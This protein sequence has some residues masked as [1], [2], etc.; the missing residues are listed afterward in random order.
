MPT[1]TPR[2]HRIAV[3]EDSDALREELLSWLGRADLA[4]GFVSGGAF[5]LS[6]EKLRPDL[7]VLDLGLPGFD[8]IEIAQRVRADPR[9]RGVPILFLAASTPGDIDLPIAC[10][11][12]EVLAAPVGRKAL[13]AAVERLLAGQEPALSGAMRD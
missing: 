9:F 8:G 13:S 10:D 1:R 6:L 3:I 11:R 7:V 12:S 2:P 4:T 5:L